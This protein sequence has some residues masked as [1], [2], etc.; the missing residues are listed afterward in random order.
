MTLSSLEYDYSGDSEWEDFSS[1]FSVDCADLS[2]LTKTG[3]PKDIAKVVVWKLGC[4]KE[5]AIHWVDKKIPALEGRS[6]RQVMSEEKGII[7]IR[8][9][10]MK[11]P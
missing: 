6:P 2:A 5:R 1:S 9:L 7:I 3:V 10:L 8:S 11:M 4:N